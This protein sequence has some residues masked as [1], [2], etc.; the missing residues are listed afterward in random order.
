MRLK[1]IL[2]K[3][4]IGENFW[5]PEFSAE[6][7]LRVFYL[8]ESC[9]NG[10]RDPFILA[11]KLTLVE[12]GWTELW[13]KQY[14][15]FDD[16]YSYCM[17]ADEHG[18]CEAIE[19]FYEV[20]STQQNVVD[21]QLWNRANEF[22]SKLREILVSDRVSWDFLYGQMIPRDENFAHN[23][24][25]LPAI[26]HLR[27]PKLEAVSQAFTKGLEELSKGDAGDAITDFASSLQILLSQLGCSGNTLGKLADSARTM[28]LLDRKAAGIVIDI[29]NFRND[30][31]AHGSDPYSRKE[32]WLVCRLTS[33]M[34]VYLLEK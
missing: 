34:I 8:M 26:S 29:A 17:L 4:S 15:P 14:T 5:S 12:E 28:G 25:I 10:Y 21:Y 30:G 2:D 20:I 27:D 9:A 13:Q 11:R 3:E 7:R 22:E 31:E 18:V 32:A 1:E 6:T 16:F 33:S 24:V 19:R 23:S